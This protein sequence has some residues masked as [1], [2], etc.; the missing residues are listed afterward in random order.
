MA[1]PVDI[2]CALGTRMA[3]I[4]SEAG[5][6][7]GQ[8]DWHDGLGR[9]TDE[10]YVRELQGARFIAALRTFEGFEMP[11]VEGKEYSILTR[12]RATL[13]ATAHHEYAQWPVTG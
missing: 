6:R 1:I 10:Q 7:L 2:A 13:D 11:G 9:V 4:Q 12:S 5:G 3:S 8:C